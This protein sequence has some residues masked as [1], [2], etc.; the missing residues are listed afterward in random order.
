LTIASRLHPDCPLACLLELCPCPVIVPA[1]RTP[2]AS[3]LWSCWWSS[4]LLASSSRYCCPRCNRPAKL[5]DAPI[6]LITSASLDSPRPTLQT[7]PADIPSAFKSPR[8]PLL[9]LR[10]WLVPIARPD[11]G[12]IGLS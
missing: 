4:P 2:G 9:V 6:A 12:R 3:R 10:I 11:L 5:R 1:C 7:P 8:S